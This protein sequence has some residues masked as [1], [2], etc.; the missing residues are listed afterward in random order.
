MQR[1]LLTLGTVLVLAGL[2]WPWL[3]RLP[4]GRLPGDLHIERDGLHIFFPLTTSVLISLVL[5]VLL[6]WWRK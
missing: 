5:S 4:L 3:S 6:W 2:L 1:L